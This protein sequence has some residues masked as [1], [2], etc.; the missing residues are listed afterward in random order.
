MQFYEPLK[1]DEVVIEHSASNYALGGILTVFGY[2]ILTIPIYGIGFVGVTYIEYVP[3][4]SNSKVVYSILNLRA[5]ITPGYL[6][7]IR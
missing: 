4:S 2:V 5:S 7:V 3:G 1:D 6:F